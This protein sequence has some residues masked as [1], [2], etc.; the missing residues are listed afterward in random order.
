VSRRRVPATTGFG[1]TGGVTAVDRRTDPAIKVG[2]QALPDGVLMRTDRAWAVARSDGSVVSG[3]LPPPR[4]PHV[5]VARVLAGLTRALWLALVGVRQRGDQPG[6]RARRSWSMLRAL[7]AAE[8]V[9]L[10]LGWLV[11]RSRPPAWGHPLVEVGLWVAAVAAFRMV[12]PEAQWRYHGAEHKAVTAYERG[13]DLHDVDLVLGC[14]RVHPRCGTNLVVWLAACAPLLSRLPGIAQLAALP[15][16]LAVIAEIL[17]AAA[18]RPGSRLARLA[19]APGAAVQTWVTTKE[20]TADEQRVGC[21]ALQ[22]CLDRHRGGRQLPG[23][24]D[25]RASAGRVTDG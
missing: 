22:A 11:A 16:A 19:L 14:P 21:T 1:D 3:D 24:A 13:V 20:P 4:W 6:D 7:V 17:T 8:A 10:G 18:R 9:V 23:Y 15:L 25:R 5:P 2:G 12:A